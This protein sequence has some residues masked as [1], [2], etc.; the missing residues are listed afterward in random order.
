MEVYLVPE[1]L[2][3]NYIIKELRAFDYE[4]LEEF[5]LRFQRG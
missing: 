4:Y 2:S 1:R 5:K 3:L